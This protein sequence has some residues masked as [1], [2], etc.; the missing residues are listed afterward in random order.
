MLQ[1]IESG[2][3]V[4]PLSNTYDT[5][6]INGDALTGDEFITD[7]CRVIGAYYL[8]QTTNNIT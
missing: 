5:D 4:T 6:F 8:E 3:V 7:G 2:I 1:I